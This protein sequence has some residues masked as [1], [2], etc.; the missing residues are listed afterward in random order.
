MYVCN[1]IYTCVHMK[2]CM[3][4][5]VYIYICI[6]IG[7]LHN[8]IYVYTFHNRELS[9]THTKISSSRVICV[10]ICIYVYTYIHIYT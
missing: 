5:Y 4:M 6:C 3:W 1:N 2:V 7:T 9:V 8:D 10:Y